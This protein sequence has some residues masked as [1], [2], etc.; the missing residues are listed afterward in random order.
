MNMTILAL[1]LG[2]T[3]GWA[4]RLMFGR[5]ERLAAPPASAVPMRSV[6]GAAA[7]HGTCSE[8]APPTKTANPRG[9]SV[10]LPVAG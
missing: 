8:P 5:I 6:D 4:L 3:T 10:A 9:R 2:T 1:D 7:D